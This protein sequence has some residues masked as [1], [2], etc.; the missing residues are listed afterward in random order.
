MTKTEL[1]RYATR[2]LIADL[3]RRM[4][5]SKRANAVAMTEL[6]SLFQRRGFA[7]T[8]DAGPLPFEAWGSLSDLGEAPSEGDIA[9]MRSSVLGRRWPQEGGDGE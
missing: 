9:E 4:A 3:E 6:T 5:S 7:V 1:W 2:E 8:P